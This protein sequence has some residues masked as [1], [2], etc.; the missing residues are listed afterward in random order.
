MTETLV[1]VIGLGCAGAG[2]AC[3]A[4]HIRATG[5]FLGALGFALLVLAAYLQ[6]SL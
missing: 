6:G 1:A 2:G 3:F 4:L 5:A